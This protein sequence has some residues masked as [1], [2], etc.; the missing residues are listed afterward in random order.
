MA[1]EPASENQT[2]HEFRRSQRRGGGCAEGDLCIRRLRGL[3][4]GPARNRAQRKSV[5]L[6]KTES[7]I[8]GTGS[9]AQTL[10]Q[11][12]ETARATGQ[13][14]RWRTRRSIAK[15]VTSDR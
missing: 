4:R 7:R 5:G 11:H 1:K 12:H 3:E 10:V 6:T 13:I 15:L 2:E 9:V 8:V 14:A